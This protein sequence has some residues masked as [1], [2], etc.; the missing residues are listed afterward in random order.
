MAEIPH[1]VL[2]EQLEERLRGRRLVAAVFLTFR[3][4]PEF[5]EQEI[6]PIFLDVPLS[7]ASAIKLVQLEDALLSVPDG[8]AV[9]YDQN[10]LVPEAG[11][12]R[13]DVKRIAV[14]HRTGI[15]HPKNVF[16]LVEDVEPDEDGHL[17]RTLIVACLSA[18]LTR[19]GWWENV[20]VCHSEEIAEG[21]FTRLRE[22]LIGFLEG[23]E[24]RV[25]EKTSDGHASLRAIRSFLRTTEQR[26]KRSSEG[27]LHTH[28]FDGRSSFPDF[29]RHVAGS[30]LDGMCL[31]IISPYFDEGPTS[32][33]L[34]DLINQFKPREV[35]VFLP[36]AHTGEAL[37]SQQIYEW[38]RRLPDVNWAKLPHELLRGGKSEDARQRTVH[39]KVYRFFTEQP[40]REILF[41]GSVNLT[42]P[43]HRPGGNL[44]TG[45]LVELSPTRR[46]DWW[47]MADSSRPREYKPCLENE[48]NTASG[49]TKLSVRFWWNTMA[50]E[51]YWD[52]S[53]LSP[54]LSV[55][56]Q[57][58]EVF[59]ADVLPSREWRSLSTEACAELQRVL[60]STSILT[61]A[62]EGQEPRLLLVQEEG[63]SHRPSLLFD[64]SPSE[65]LRYW[66]LL[67]VA[68][69]AA[70][71]DA[72]APDVALLGEGAALVSGARPLAQESTFFDRFAGI[73]LAFGNLERSV[74]CA[75]REGR[76][77]EATY[78]L[79]GK[80]Y[81][82]LGTLLNRLFKDS[83]D[84]KG[85]FIDHY[86]VAL[87]ARQLVQELRRDCA[88]FWLEHTSDAEH[89][90][91][92]LRAVAHIRERLTDR[93]PTEMA[94]FLDWFD[95]WFLQRATPVVPEAS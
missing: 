47:L 91:E 10:G 28:F 43:A 36:R 46:P 24:R 9:Y 82:S 22:D 70:F 56:A 23:L 19:A 34:D 50:A 13:L 64:L 1:A 89:L 79:F 38:V 78:R 95:R 54:K 63:M 85:D 18:N 77:S 67:T 60:R 88:E 35:R 76:K 75:L 8:V 72:R 48:G 94:E 92:Q 25:G 81:D 4:D 7:H 74:R 57:G 86:V 31:E 16:A 87:C 65:I 5:F 39:A 90:Q 51:V 45:F 73:F 41:V 14:R 84:G 80:K 21:D 30:S 17:P 52:D 40:K 12:A 33:P 93:N 2:S 59:E 66:S 42:S 26:T 49:G 61:V 6:L 11:P 68:Q 3:F 32:V 27:I 69:R 58:V 20:E 29:L 55:T 44:E 15:F 37:C 83:A 53:S 62:G 71:L